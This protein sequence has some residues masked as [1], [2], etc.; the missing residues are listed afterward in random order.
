MAAHRVVALGGNRTHLESYAREF[1]ADPRCELVAVADE[2]DVSGYRDALN[3]LL[4]TELGVQ[5]TR[6][7]PSLE[8]VFL[9]AIAR[10]PA[11]EAT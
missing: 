9:E 8:D 5:V 2:T 3:R 6:V 4:A 10:E 1:A 11:Q 7:R